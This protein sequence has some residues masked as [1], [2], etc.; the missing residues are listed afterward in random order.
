MPLAT[1]LYS[2]SRGLTASRAERR[3]AQPPQTLPSEPYRTSMNHLST[4]DD[5]LQAARSQPTP[6]RLLFVFAGAQLPEDASPAQRASFEAGEG[7]ALEPLMT[8]DKPPD[9]LTD[10]KALAD[11]SASFG[12]EWSIV[13]VGAMS[14]QGGQ[15]PTS[16]DAAAPLQR[17][18]E[19]IK[20][21]VPGTL[22]TFDRQGQVVSLG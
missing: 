7:G 8:V 10:F 22:M 19:S 6:Q 4:F 13:F 20:Q 2:R 21:G 12:P 17:M 3:V 16:E 15:Q 9:E 1:G 14:G 11:E 5:L 18:V